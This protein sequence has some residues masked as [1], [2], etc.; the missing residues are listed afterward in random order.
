MK[1]A[2]RIYNYSTPFKGFYL[3]NDDYLVVDL[4]QTSFFVFMY[5]TS[6][7]RMNLVHDLPFIGLIIA[8]D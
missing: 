3:F 6:I 5:K 8:Y 7:G 1:V 4:G 2:R